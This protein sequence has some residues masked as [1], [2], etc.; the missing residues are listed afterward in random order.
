MTSGGV[1][2]EAQVTHTS[3]NQTVLTFNTAISGI[4][5]FS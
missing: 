1:E 2:T 4:A 5:R 3:P